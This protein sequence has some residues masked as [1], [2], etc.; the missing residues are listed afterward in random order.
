M[1]LDRGPER[2]DLNLLTVFD[3]VMTERHVTRASE[4]LGLTQSAVSNALNRLRKQFQ[5]VLFV[6]AAR[7][8]EP[9]Q[10]AL[11]LWPDIHTAIGQLNQVL[12]PGQFSAESAAM[13][14]RMSMVD[15][16]A[17]L[18]TPHLFQC[19]QR[20]GPGIGLSFVPHVPELTAERLSRGEVDFAISVEPP[21][22]AVLETRLLWSEAYV[23]AGHRDHP[24]LRSRISTE[25]LCQTP[26]LMVN[27]SGSPS[28]RHPV[29]SYLAERGLERPI[30][31]IVN[32]FLVATAMLRESELL[33]ILPMRLAADRF[34]RNWL[35]YQELPFAVTPA[36]L[37]LIWHRRNN[38][39]PAMTW[40][41][42]RIVEATQ[43]MNK[44]FSDD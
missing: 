28:F 26:Q 5:D 18:L 20:A 34:T 44:V 10:R 16:S 12:R 30:K 19:I 33:A 24:A 14:F 7:G 9:T 4:R 6:K 17:A 42:E 13:E 21:R 41:R 36:A 1:D 15:L 39:L 23:I 29:D 2:L 27:L 8:V 25:Q 31:L 35:T 32:Q 38:G 37:Y 40:L 11:A 22:M 3:T 43:A